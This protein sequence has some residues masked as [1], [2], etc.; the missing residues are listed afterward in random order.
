MCIP[1]I[2]YPG[3]TNRQTMR[4]PVTLLALYLSAHPLSSIAQ[5]ASPA[6]PDSLRAIVALPGIEVRSTL[7]AA[8][9]LEDGVM[10]DAGA[11]R[12]LPATYADPA[13]L[14][15]MLPG[16][17]S[18]NDQTNALVV[19][20]QD[21]RRVQWALIGLPIVNPN[22]LSNAGT[23]TDRA[24]AAAG[25]VNILSSEMLQSARLYRYDT[26]LRLGGARPTLDMIPRHAQPSLQGNISIG[27]LGIEGGADLPT[28]LGAVSGHARQATVAILTGLG[29]DFGG[30]RIQ[31]ADFSL[32]HAARLGPLTVTSAALWGSSTNDF[33]GLPDPYTWTD[34][35]DARSITFENSMGGIA[36]RLQGL[37]RPTLHFEAGLSYSRRDT[38]RREIRR[39]G[40]ED[41]LIPFSYDVWEDLRESMLAYQLSLVHRPSDH[42]AL[43]VG[44]LGVSEQFLQLDQRP[45]LVRI[46]TTKT[47][48]WQPYLA[49]E[50]NT[51]LGPITVE[52]QLL[53]VEGWDHAEWGGRFGWT[54]PLS[55]PSGLHARIASLVEPRRAAD[56]F[57]YAASESIRATL[58]EVG[59]RHERFLARETPLL[60]EL[61][62]FYRDEPRDDGV[63]RTAFDFDGWPPPMEVSSRQSG[64]EL[65][66]Y[67]QWPTGR[68]ARLQATLSRATEIDVWIH[69]AALQLPPRWMASP[70]DAGHDLGLTVGRERRRSAERIS[71]WSAQWTWRGG[72]QEPVL[73]EEP[74]RDTNTSVYSMLERNALG[75]FMRIDVRWYRTKLIG[76]HLR[77]WSLDIQNLTARQNVAF[78]RWDDVAREVETIYQLGLI[79]ILTYRRTF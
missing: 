77:T 15:L 24:T 68:Y 16:V 61:T 44:L 13:R 50:R 66:A 5:E 73:L 72:W 46:P 14:A 28:P 42:H 34:W 47:H 71:G 35:R 8:T 4:I 7:S 17:S 60:L 25:G 12:T 40:P 19:R 54:S 33:N 32:T 59:L 48:L 56:Q 30:E 39:D 43:R 6:Q 64:I 21:P 45:T 22:H 69:P 58:A 2:S 79:P 41:V 74:S 55:A 65:S 20:A 29:A 75:D 38:Y 63:Y 26:P 51:R 53:I 52:G 1:K 78:Q 49:L 23:R 67:L 57:F 37:L 62:G 27:L 36:T 10:L 3:W 76:P 9:F 31:F 18:A 11:I 70:W